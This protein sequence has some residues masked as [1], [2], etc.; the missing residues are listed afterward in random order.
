MS[1]RPKRPRRP[2]STVI[3][4]HHISYCVEA[5]QKGTSICKNCKYRNKRIGCWIVKVIKGEHWILTQLQ[6]RR[7][8]SIGFLISLQHLVESMKEYAVEL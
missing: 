1:K 7:R 3:Q 6:R 4:E 2:H 5:L 8:V